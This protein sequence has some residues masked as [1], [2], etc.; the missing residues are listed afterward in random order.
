MLWVYNLGL[1]YY[2]R[3]TG[4]VRVI[5]KLYQPYTFN[6]TNVTDWYILWV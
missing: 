6:E 2:L 4:E 1:T 5:P 3:K